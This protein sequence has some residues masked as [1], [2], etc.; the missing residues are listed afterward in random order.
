LV[1]IAVIDGQGAGI[2]S[3]IIR[4]VQQTYGAKVEILALGTNAI[5]TGQMM[6]AGAN[7]GATGESAV[8]HWARQVDIII[9]S[10]SILISNS[11]MGEVTP[12]MAVAIGNSGAV[13]LLLPLTTEPVKVVG[14]VPVPLPHL[15]DKLVSEHLPGLI[16]YREGLSGSECA[17]R[18]PG[19][20]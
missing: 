8:C 10:I 13:K 17:V 14:S 19:K 16:S 11:M 3:T 12:A 6:K 5:A 15:V 20:R 9:G 2:G 7:R 4:K 18:V 1:R